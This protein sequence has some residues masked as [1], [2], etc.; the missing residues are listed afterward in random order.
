MM[1]T[2]LDLSY[3]YHPTI[4]LEH[5]KKSWGTSHYLVTWLAQAKMPRLNTQGNQEN[6]ENQENEMKCNE[7]NQEIKKARKPDQ[8]ISFHS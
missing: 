7:W 2:P 3:K 8:T 5:V 6:Q 4:A 1:D